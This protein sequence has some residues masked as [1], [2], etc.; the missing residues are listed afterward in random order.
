MGYI[1]LTMQQGQRIM[2]YIIFRA[3][4]LGE[5][6]ISE[7]NDDGTTTILKQ[8]KCKKFRKCFYELGWFI[9]GLGTLIALQGNDIKERDV[10]MLREILISKSYRQPKKVKVF[11]IGLRN[12]LTHKLWAWD[13]GPMPDELA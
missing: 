5:A 4:C 10:E 13:Q 6:W 7:A 2:P 11:N 3:E 12:T 1:T 9:D 8:F